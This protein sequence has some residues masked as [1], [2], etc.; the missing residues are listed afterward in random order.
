MRHTKLNFRDGGLAGFIYPIDDG[1]KKSCS[2][3]DFCFFLEKVRNHI[4]REYVGVQLCNLS[5]LFTEFFCETTRG[6]ER[7][8]LQL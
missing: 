4:L 8:V 6:D 1:D 3:S 5:V 2:N 7:C